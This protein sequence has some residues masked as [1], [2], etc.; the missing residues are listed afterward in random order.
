VSA[1]DEIDRLCEVNGPHLVRAVL[2]FLRDRTHRLPDEL[3]GVP[4]SDRLGNI[5]RALSRHGSKPLV[6]DLE[7]YAPQILDLIGTSFSEALEH[8]RGRL[9]GART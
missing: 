8:T 6:S 4:L 9:A 3:D 2:A 1:E 7:R 5:Q